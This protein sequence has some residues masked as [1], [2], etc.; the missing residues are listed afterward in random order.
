MDE[1][2]LPPA[3]A[4]TSPWALR[5]AGGLVFGLVI[6]PLI[7]LLCLPILLFLGL[8]KREVL[9][10]VVRAASYDAFE[11]TPYYKDP[12]RL[13]RVFA[14]P[15]GQLYR[16]GGL[17]YQAREGYCS[18]ATQRNLLKSLPLVLPSQLPPARG[19]AATAA[20][21]ADALLRHSHGLVTSTQVVYG[22]DGVDAFCAALRLANDE[23]HRVAVN[24]LHATLSGT[25]PLWLPWN[26]P[27]GVVSGHFSNVVGFLDDENLVAIFD[28]NDGYGAYLVDA[29]RLFE[30]VCAVDISSNRSRALIVASIA[31][32][33]V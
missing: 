17:E 6:G 23:N 21:F 13:G 2:F 5:A 14:T 26:L 19:G 20:Q 16:R 25:G 4:D 3:R 10:P 27:L 8:F 7:A 33:R 9:R 12:A 11:K 24:F 1:D 31:S 29:T 32:Q 22:S 18:V 30:A 28:V 15:V